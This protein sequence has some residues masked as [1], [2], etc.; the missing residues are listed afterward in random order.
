MEMTEDNIEKVITEKSRLNDIDFENLKFGR[1]FSDHLFLADYFD[2]K[3]QSKKI[4]PY[5]EMSFSP[6]NSV[7]HYGQAIFEG[8]KAYKS[9]DDKVLLF[10]PEENFKRMNRSAERMCMPKLPREIFMDG[11]TNLIDLDRNWVPE[12]LGKSLNIR[13]LMISDENFLGVTLD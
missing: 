11:L 6:G 12:G 7:F 13:P 2:G 9:N 10:R 3:W 8:L 1:E 5:S 4:M